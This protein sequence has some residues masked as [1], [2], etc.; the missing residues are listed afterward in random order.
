[1]PKGGTDTGLREGSGIAEYSHFV[2]YGT[3]KPPRVSDMETE[4]VKQV[5]ILLVTIPF[6]LCAESHPQLIP[7]LRPQG[8]SAVCEAVPG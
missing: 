3:E 2:S 6:C 1:M 4:D 5:L 8:R 7:A